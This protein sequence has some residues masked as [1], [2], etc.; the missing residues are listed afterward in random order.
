MKILFKIILLMT[1][2]CTFSCT[3]NSKKSSASTR[4]YIII[5]SNKITSTTTEIEC[6]S[7]EMISS[8]KIIFWADG[9]KSTVYSDN[10]SISNK[11]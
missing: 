8:K 4:K 3:K 2:L 7:F 9:A 11:K 1:L 5:M 10:I 6:D